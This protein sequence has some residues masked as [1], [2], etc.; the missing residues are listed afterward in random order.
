MLVPFIMLV[1]MLVYDAKLCTIPFFS[2]RFDH[3]NYKNF[4]KLY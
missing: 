3:Y 4:D 1:S 2:H